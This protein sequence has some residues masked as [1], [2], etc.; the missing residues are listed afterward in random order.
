M[1]SSYPC[2]YKHKKPPELVPAKYYELDVSSILLGK[3]LPS[4]PVIF[5]LSIQNNRMF[6]NYT[7]SEESSPETSNIIFRIISLVT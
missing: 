7:V 1:T 2:A 5:D 4:T 3:I 6:E